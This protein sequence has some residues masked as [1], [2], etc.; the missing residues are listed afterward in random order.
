[1]AILHAGLPSVRLT[2]L[3]R[4][5]TAASVAVPASVHQLAEVPADGGLQWSRGGASLVGLA[6]EML[7]LEST[8]LTV[9]PTGL[10]DSDQDLYLRHQH[11][12]QEQQDA[13]VD[14]LVN[15]WQQSRAFYQGTMLSA[16]RPCVDALSFP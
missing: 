10:G 14:Q 4:V 2:S 7:P 11:A 3:R 15:R 9:E 5:W 8:C 16:C 6:L 13:Q 1:M 12:Q